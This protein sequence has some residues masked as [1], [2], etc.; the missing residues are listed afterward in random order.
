MI[1]KKLVQVVHYV[2]IGG[3]GGESKTSIYPADSPEFPDTKGLPLKA[4]QTN[5]EAELES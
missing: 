2:Y 4:I 5:L 3:I 1:G